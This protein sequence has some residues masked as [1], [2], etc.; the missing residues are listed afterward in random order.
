[1]NKL[2]DMVLDKEAQIRDKR[3]QNLKEA[4]KKEP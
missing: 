4:K 1:M 2:D 3:S